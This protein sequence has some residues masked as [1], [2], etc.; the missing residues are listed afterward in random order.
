M[1]SE[2]WLVTK[3]NIQPAYLNMDAVPRLIELLTYGRASTW[4]EACNLYEDELFKLRMID[5]GERQLSVQEDMLAA[6]KDLVDL[7][8][9]SINL[10]HISIEL[11]QA[12][13]N[14]QEQMLDAQRAVSAN[15]ADLIA[16]AI[17][18]NEGH[19]KVMKEMAKIRKNTGC[20]KNAARVSAFTDFN[21][22][23]F[24]R[25]VKI[26]KY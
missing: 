16:E 19:Q 25:R 6:Q 15:T 21:D 14:L 9:E 26:V 3:A 11:Q 23:F 10:Q 24:G 4:K 22:M 7:S 18:M 17:K 5:I 8:I 12:G 1:N 20:T 13:F 2:R